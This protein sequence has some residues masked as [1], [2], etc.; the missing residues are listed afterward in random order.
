MQIRSRC[1]FCGDVEMEAK[2]VHLTVAE[3]GERG[4]YSFNCPSCQVIVAKAA[5]R[6]IIGL[7]T[8]AGV[9]VDER[10]NTEAEPQPLTIDDL[11]DFHAELEEKGIGGFLA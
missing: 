1:P 3:D 8:G 7:L 9:N 6:K 2:A 11:I 10:K 4:A 5:D